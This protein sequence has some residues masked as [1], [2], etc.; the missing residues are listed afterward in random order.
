[1]N[2]AKLTHRL[3]ELKC[4]FYRQAAGAH[5][6]WWHPETG[7]RTVISNHG[8]KDIPKGTLRAIAHDLGLTLE[9]LLHK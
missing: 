8:A 9:E 5:E 2:Y 3:R 4:E 1:M 7:R 6:I